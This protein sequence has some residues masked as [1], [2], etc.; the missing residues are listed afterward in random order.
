MLVYGTSEKRHSA[1][2]LQY[3]SLLDGEHEAS[4]SAFL[5]CMTR[6]ADEICPYCFALNL[7]ARLR[8]G[9]SSMRVKTER[10]MVA[11]LNVQELTKLSERTLAAEY[12]KIMGKGP[13]RIKEGA[14]EERIAEMLAKLKADAA[15]NEEADPAAPSTSGKAPKAPKAAKAAKPPKEPKEPKATKA[16][17]AAKAPKAAKPP[18][19][20]K[21]AKKL[22]KEGDNPFREGTMKA[23]GFDF[24]LKHQEDPADCIAHMIKKGAT[25]STARGWLSMYRKLG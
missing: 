3:F 7:L 16:A 4:A 23:A 14:K 6:G 20:P 11:M 19:A 18:K 5:S 25:E 21:A 9:T 13:D 24:F 15:K 2:E 17:K 12:K 10:K 22:V 8:T 1:G